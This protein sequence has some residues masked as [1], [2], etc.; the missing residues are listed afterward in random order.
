[1]A[2]KKL[3]DFQLVNLI[4]ELYFRSLLR[5]QEDCETI[6]LICDKMHTLNGVEKY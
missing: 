5:I 4:F 1:M 2:F 3:Y 6:T